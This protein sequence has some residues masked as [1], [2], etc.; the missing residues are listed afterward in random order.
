MF[1]T[2]IYMYDCIDWIREYFR[3]N[4]YN[5]M[6][7]VGIS[8]GIDSAVVAAMCVKALGK[9]RVLGILM[10]NGVQSDIEVAKEVCDTLEINYYVANIAEAVEGIYNQLHSDKDYLG[11]VVMYNTPARIRMTMLYAYAAMVRGRVANTCNLSESYVGYDT[12]WGDNAGDF[13]PLQEFTKTEIYEMAALLPLPQSVLNAIPNDGMCG[14]SDEERFGFTYATLDK[15]I[16]GGANLSYEEH[17]RITEMHS[18]ARHK[19]TAVNLPHYSM[20]GKR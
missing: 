8:G 5:S 16:R 12:K 7:V 9:E 4:G 6:A 2:K 10:P 17:K 15:F 14:V 13:A 19:L 11:P 1:E 20:E 3:L 18:A